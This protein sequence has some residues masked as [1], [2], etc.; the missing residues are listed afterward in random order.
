[1]FGEDTYEEYLA[2]SEVL[3]RWADE[4]GMAE[5][6]C[7]PMTEEAWQADMD[8]RAERKRLYEEPITSVEQVRVL[9]DRGFNVEGPDTDT[10][11]RIIEFLLDGKE[12]T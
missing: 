8:W 10:V 2:Q 5:L 9:L 12:T 11:W 7:P 4:N 1:M 6:K 3:D